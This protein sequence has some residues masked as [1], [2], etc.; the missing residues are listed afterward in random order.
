MALR[1][2]DVLVSGLGQLRTHALDAHV[3]ARLGDEIIVS[4]DHALLV[5]EPGR[6]VPTYAVP[7]GDVF[8]D[9]VDEAESSTGASS[10]TTPS[11]STS[12]LD[13][14]TPFAT[15]TA[16]GRSLTVRTAGQGGVE[17]AAYAFDDPDLT[18]YVALDFAAFSAWMEEEDEVLGH[19]QDPFHRVACRRT[20]KHVV[21]T[22][23]GEVLADTREAVLLLETNL[24]G[25][26]YIPRADVRRGVLEPSSTR[27]LCPYKG[28]ASYWTARVG[29]RL[30]ADLAWSYEQP[31]TEAAPVGGHLCFWNER[32]DLTVDGE[33]VAR[34]RT[35]WSED[36]DSAT[37]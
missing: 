16:P 5:W 29:D 26:Y 3:R 8:G 7:G 6:I 20:T 24:P 32:T 11:A 27:S 12:A 36:P 25:R 13:P 4:S 33:P 14:R 2:K 18:G 37:Q 31:L 1:M 23:D 10:G 21:V 15:H 22:R 19:P 35:R 30:V 9:L 28:E 17:G 34:P